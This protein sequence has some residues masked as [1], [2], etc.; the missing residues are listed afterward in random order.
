MADICPR[1]ICQ[2]LRL[3]MISPNK[4]NQ[5]LSLLVSR[6][7]NESCKKYLECLPEEAAFMV[8]SCAIVTFQVLRLGMISPKKQFKF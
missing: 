3:E 2:V 4:T 6:C 7:N 8:Y 1:D 5:V